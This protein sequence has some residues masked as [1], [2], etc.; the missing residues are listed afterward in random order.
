[1]RSP[2][3]AIAIDFDG[4]I[5]FRGHEIP[6]ARESIEQL[7]DRGYRV[8]IHTLRAR[9]P[10]GAAHVRDWLDNHDIQYHEVTALKPNALFFIDDR[11]IRFDIWPQALNEVLDRDPMGVLE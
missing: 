2:L 10:S 1:M 7:L 6:Q 11:A 9:T 8:I 5:A 3:P 4:V